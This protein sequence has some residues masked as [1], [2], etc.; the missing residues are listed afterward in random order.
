MDRKG[1]EF[2]FLQEKFPPISLEK[3]KPGIFDGPQIREL[4]KYPMMTKHRVKLNCLPVT[5]V[6]NYKPSGK[7]PECRI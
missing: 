4:M 7:P 6:S 1:S 3:H 2:A 5:E